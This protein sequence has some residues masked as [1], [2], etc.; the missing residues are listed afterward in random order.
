MMLLDLTGFRIIM[1]LAALGFYIGFLFI[2]P[3][4]IE[5]RIKAIILYRKQNQS[6]DD[7]RRGNNEGL[8]EIER[9]FFRFLMFLAWIP[10]LNSIVAIVLWA[11]SFVRAYFHGLSECNK[12]MKRANALLKPR[13]KDRT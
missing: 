10:L 6:L 4:M 2:L 5:T 8:T 9:R 1:G 7:E 11:I 3:M 12:S 13:P